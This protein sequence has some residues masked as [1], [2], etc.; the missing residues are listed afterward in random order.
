MLIVQMHILTFKVARQLN[1]LKYQEIL[2]A[3]KTIFKIQQKTAKP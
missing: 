2:S 1:I 3:F